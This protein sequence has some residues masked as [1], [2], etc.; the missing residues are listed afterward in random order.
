MNSILSNLISNFFN[1]RSS[2]AADDLMEKESIL[3]SP[4]YLS[5]AETGACKL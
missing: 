3:D 5:N 1:P 2:C 4:N